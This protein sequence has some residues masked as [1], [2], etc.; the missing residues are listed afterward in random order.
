MATSAAKA[1]LP[2][3]QLAA[4]FPTTGY[5][6]PKFTNTLIGIGPICDA[7]YTVVFKR[8]DVTVISPRGK[9]IIQWWREKKLPRIWRFALKRVKQKYTRTNQKRLEAAIIVYDLPIIEALVRYMHA[10]E[11]FPVKST[12]CNNHKE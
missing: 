7:N 11:G 12:W 8:Q 4:D 6:I 9:P 3:P 1:T 2:I 10:A 5:I